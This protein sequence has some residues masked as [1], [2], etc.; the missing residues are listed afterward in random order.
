MRVLALDLGTKRVGVAVSDVTA[1]LATPRTTILRSGN[2]DVEHRQV[3][4]IVAEEGAVLVVVGLPLNMD[5][6]TGPS[7]RAA[8]DEATALALVLDVPVEMADERLTTVV[9]DRTLRGQGRRAPA[10]R[11]VVDQTAAAVLLQTWL[12]GPRGS[13]FRTVAVRPPC[14]SPGGHGASVDG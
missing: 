6:S 7:A 4:Q 5:G 13:Q 3:A 2:R 1:T 8:R 10:R 9:A 11:L 14:G 12:D